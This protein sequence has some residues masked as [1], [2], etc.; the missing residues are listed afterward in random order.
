MVQNAFKMRNS[1][2]FNAKLKCMMSC[3]I[4]PAFDIHDIIILMVKKK[5]YLIIIIAY[6]KKYIFWYSSHK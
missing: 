2:S 5:G 6:L 1:H 4:N 3:K